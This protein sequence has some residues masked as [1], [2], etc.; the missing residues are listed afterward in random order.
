VLAPFLGLLAIVVPAMV[1]ATPA[2]EAPLF[3]LVASGVEHMSR[4][5]LLLFFAAGVFLGGAFRHK[6]SWVAS[7]VVMAPMPIIILM[8]GIKDPTSHNLWP[9]ELLLYGG[10]TLLSL[11]GA[12]IG[13]V[14]RRVAQR[15]S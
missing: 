4:L 6:A 15:A 11:L 2:E 10:L 13:A 3:P 5:T 1:L 14:G 12:V 7:L 8:E 9:F